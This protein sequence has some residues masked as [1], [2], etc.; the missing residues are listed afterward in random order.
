MKTFLECF[1]AKLGRE[2]I[3]KPATEAESLLENSSNN[4]V[5]VVNFVISKNVIIMSVIFVHQNSRKCN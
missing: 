5:R 4:G 3:F 1:N 2:G